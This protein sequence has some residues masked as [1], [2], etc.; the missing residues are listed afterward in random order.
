M[1]GYPRIS[2][3]TVRKIRRKCG[4]YQRQF[5]QRFGVS[6]R[7][8]IRWEQDGCEFRYWEVGRAKVWKA[9]RKKHPSLFSK[10]EREAIDR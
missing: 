7:T 6:K 3:D 4:E 5:A 1:W 10:A 9:L 8:I 2:G